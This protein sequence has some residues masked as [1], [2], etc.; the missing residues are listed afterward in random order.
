MNKKE[1]AALAQKFAGDCIAYRVR[2]LNRVIT[3]LY[4]LALKPF[5]ITVN[6]TTMRAMLI[7]VGK[8]RPGDCGPARRGDA[9]GAQAAGRSIPGKQCR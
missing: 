6:Q 1:A 9:G 2:A 8:F 5:G 4:D 3:H 7:L